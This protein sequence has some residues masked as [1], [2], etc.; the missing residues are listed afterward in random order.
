[1][2]LLGRGGQPIT[3]EATR[4]ALLAVGSVSWHRAGKKSNEITL[5][6]CNSARRSWKTELGL[7]SCV[8]YLLWVC[9]L[10]QLHKSGHDDHPHTDPSGPPS[11]IKGSWALKP[12]LCLVGGGGGASSRCL[13]APIHLL[14]F[15]LLQ[16]DEG[17]THEKL[18]FKLHFSCASYLI[19]TPCYR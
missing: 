9:V 7:F 15:D 12:R 18:D 11:F 8:P 13:G 19:T 4:C 10:T 5:I 14:S 1:M 3:G 16:N 2:R 17:S 6:R